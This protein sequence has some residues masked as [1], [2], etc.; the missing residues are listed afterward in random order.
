MIKITLLTFGVLVLKSAELG[1]GMVGG[2]LWVRI[3]ATA[4][5][6]PTDPIFPIDFNDPNV[7]H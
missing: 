1:L 5:M 7:P 3:G 2:G 4:P 6:S